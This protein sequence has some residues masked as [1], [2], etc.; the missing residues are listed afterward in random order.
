MSRQLTEQDFWLPQVRL[1]DAQVREI[2]G[3]ALIGR[4]QKDLASAFGVSIALISMILSGKR[5]AA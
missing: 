3:L 2:R 4:P 5:R 1:S